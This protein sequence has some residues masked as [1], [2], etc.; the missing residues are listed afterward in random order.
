[1]IG[2][3]IDM[4]MAQFRADYL[5]RWLRELA[6]IG[7]NTI[8]WEA[9]NNV[10]WE[11]CP[12]CV[13]P[14]AFSKKEFKR[15]LDLCHELGLESVPLL[16]TL[17]HSEYA[18]K[19]DRYRDLREEPKGGPV[20]GPMDC[21]VFRSIRTAASLSS[22][23]GRGRTAWPLRP[24]PGVCRETLDLGTVRPAHQRGEPVR[25]EAGCEADHMGGYDS[26]ASGG[27]R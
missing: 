16:Q 19:H 3:H 17:G 1:M 18:L 10:R 24:M 15:L 11:T 7:Y 23:R 25:A 21:G 13:A 20:P 22:G 12:E 8:L 5:E 27:A 6:R 4:N 26:E 2:F 14:E 9:E